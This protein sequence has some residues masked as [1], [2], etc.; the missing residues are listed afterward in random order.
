MKLTSLLVLAMALMLVASAV[1]ECSAQRDIP[2]ERGG[3]TH[4]LG[5]PSAYRGRTGVEF[6]WYRPKG[7]SDPMG[8][9]NLG[10]SKGLGNPTLSIAS[11][12]LE[13]YIGVAAEDL[14]GG[15][16]ALFEV[17]TLYIGGGVDY[18]ATTGDFDFIATLDLPLRRSGL[19]G[20]GT[21]LGVRWLPGREQTVSLGLN[22]PIGNLH[23]GE[24]R[25]PRDAVHLRELDVERLEADQVLGHADLEPGL[26]ALKERALWVSRLT[27][28]FAEYPGS[29]ARE[30]MEAPLADLVAHVASTGPQFPSGHSLPEEIR[31][32]HET[33]DE[34]FMNAARGDAELGNQIGI[35]ARKFLLE[36][37]LIPYNYLFGQRKVNDGLSPMVAV[38]QTRFAGWVLSE[39]ELPRDDARRVFFVFQSLCD[40]T[41]EV[42]RELKDRWEDTR[43]VWLPLELALTP[44][45]HDTQQELND[46]ISLATRTPF[47]HDNRVWHIVNEEFQWEM[48]RSVREARDYHVLWIH[49]YRGINGEGNPDV[50]AYEHTLNYLEALIDRVRDYDESGKIPKYFIF[51]DQHFFEVNKGRMF[52][53]LL[54]DP[55]DYELSLPKD[56][57]EWE[58]NIRATQE[59]LRTAVAESSLL[60]IS[61]TQFSRDWLKN[62]IKV[63]VN[64]TNP[65]DRS[66]YS[67]HVAGW[68]PMPDN[69]MRD[70]R[71]IAFYDISEEDPYRGMGMFTG[72]GIGEH[73]V[74]ANWEDRALMIQGPAALGLKDAARH[75]LEIQ[76]FDPHEMPYAFRQLPKA[77]DYELKI[78]N[79]HE[80]KTPD[81]AEDRGQILQLH[82]E[83]GFVDKPVSV[84]KAMLYS[85]MPS[86]SVI[87]S[88]DSLWQSY[89]Y[90][91]LL[92]GSA[93]RGCRV[94][95]IAPTLASAPSNAKPTMERARGVLGRV[96]VFGDVMADELAAQGG[97]IKIG[98]YAP[99][100]G[101]GD[102][103]G[104]IAQSGSTRPSWADEVYPANP[105]LDAMIAR[106]PQILDDMGFE[107]EYLSE[108]GAEG[109]PKIHLKADFAASADAWDRLHAHPKLAEVV[110][111]YVRYLAEQ[112]SAN[113]DDGR[114]PDVRAMPQEL[115]D[116][117]FELIEDLVKSTP[118]EKRDELVYFFTAGSTNMDYR[119]IV[120][121]GEVMVVLAGWQA[122]YG[123]LDFL[124]LPGLCDWVETTE[125][126]DEQIPPGGW[127]TRWAAGL[128]KLM[129]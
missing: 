55:L 54:E 99:D 102:L 127:F 83:T 53:R 97:L 62:Q 18:S 125:E 111:A 26:G 58:D 72:M 76:G 30:A 94:L 122:L 15:G 124:I 44:D 101:V 109:G 73:Y 116:H 77:P 31:V 119:S 37:M 41:D 93:L 108:H 91:S 29:D 14:N 28:P 98:L 8:L 74:G 82:N 129:L 120:L 79:E 86:G 27:Q 9:F 19:A 107:F 34:L 70:H 118:P 4:S 50:M 123:F 5:I 11:W 65:A 92:A 12:R 106:V 126:I 66:Y 78:A 67:W 104:R 46:L 16:R 103:A 21:T 17:P 23:Q 57:K 85:L 20:H 22:V 52:L 2:P 115:K 113:T 42:R 87:K 128:G 51:L 48:A 24:T 81:W 96:L 110:E 6:G 69:H 25:P 75:L 47:T 89:P 60:R 35:Q 39:L 33:L 38:A 43:F 13:G 10:F 100:Q 71:K 1:G 61:G 32:Y 40:I 63:H 84:G 68:I 105:A 90:A 36:E 3:L 49:D 56:F 80:A 95:I 88:P 45:Q 121:N 59:R 117:W 112:L 114:E 64:I 7:G